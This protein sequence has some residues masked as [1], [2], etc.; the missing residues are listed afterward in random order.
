MICYWKW[1][2]VHLQEFGHHVRLATHANFSTFV[3]SAGVEFYPLGGDPHLLAGCKRSPILKFLLHQCI[4]A[5]YLSKKKK[6]CFIAIFTWYTNLVSGVVYPWF[7]PQELVQWALPWWDST[8][9]KKKKKIHCNLICFL[10][11]LY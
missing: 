2:S 3:R 5:I 10:W 4:I 11:S 6:K 8:S 9:S 7:T 1:F